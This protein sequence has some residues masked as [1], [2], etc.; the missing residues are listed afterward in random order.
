[1]GLGESI[2]LSSIFLG[3]IILFV[4]TKNRWN[5]K[6]IWIR[7]F[8][9]IF[10]L[11]FIAVIGALI[12]NKISERPRKVN[13][14]ESYCLGETKKEVIW[15]HEEPQKYIDNDTWDYSFD[16]LIDPE[17]KYY[18]RLKFKDEKVI[19]ILFLGNSLSLIRL[20]FQMRLSYLST[21]SK[22]LIEKF[23]SPSKYW[24]SN[25]H[26]Y[27]IYYFPKFNLAFLLETDRLMWLCVYNPL[28]FTPQITDFYK[29]RDTDVINN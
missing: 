19:A 10:S 7:F 5:W 14:L 17:I 3:M 25:N 4:S 28:Y 11:G 8:I 13:E 6:K 12:Y 16:D 2:L 22:E 23:G 1:M 9:I 27:R 18:Y 21:D 29:P 15:K 20:K 24:E 26:K